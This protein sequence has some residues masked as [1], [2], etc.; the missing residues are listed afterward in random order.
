MRVVK[1]ERPELEQPSEGHGP[2][3]RCGAAFLDQGTDGCRRARGD[4]IVVKF[5]LPCPQGRSGLRLVLG[6]DRL[7]ALR[8]VT[9]DRLSADEVTEAP[10]ALASLNGLVLTGAPGSIREPRTKRSSTALR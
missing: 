2:G 7:G 4:P 5:F 9:R 8:R 1:A 3:P 10:R 6:L